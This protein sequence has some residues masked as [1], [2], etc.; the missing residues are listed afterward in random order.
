MTKKEEHTMGYAIGYVLMFFI[1]LWLYLHIWV[2]VGDFIKA[3]SEFS[4]K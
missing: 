2:P 3:S 4:G 1:Y